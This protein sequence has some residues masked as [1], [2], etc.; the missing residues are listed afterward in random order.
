ME[1]RYQQKRQK[2]MTTM[3]TIMDAT[4]A[5]II[6]GVGVVLFFGPKMGMQRIEEIDPLIRNLF[7]GISI[8]YGAFRL[9]RSFKRDY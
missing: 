1:N 3:R 9:Y 4:R 6:L 8:L 5:V 7:G 2:S